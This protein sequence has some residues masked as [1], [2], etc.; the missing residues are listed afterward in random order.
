MVPLETMN[1]AP[2]SVRN[3]FP[4]LRNCSP[5]IQK[6]VLFFQLLFLTA[7]VLIASGLQ[8]WY[9]LNI[10]VP[11]L[12]ISRSKQ[13]FFYPIDFFCKQRFVFWQACRKFLAKNINR[14]NNIY[15]YNPSKNFP[16][17]VD[18]SFGHVNYSFVRCKKFF[19]KSSRSFGSKSE[20]FFGV[21][22]QKRVLL[23]ILLSLNGM[24][25]WK[26]LPKVI[27]RV[28]KTFG[29]ISQTH[30]E[31]KGSF[32]KRCFYSKN[33]WDVQC[34]FHKH[35]ENCLSK[36]R[37]VFAQS[38]KTVMKIVFILWKLSLSNGSLGNVKC[39]FDKHA[40]VFFVKYSTLSGPKS[41]NEVHFF[42]S[43]ETFHWMCSPDKWNAIL[44]TVPYV[45]STSPKNV[46][47]QKSEIYDERKYCFKK[48]CFNSKRLLRRKMQ[49][50]QTCRKVLYTT[51]VFQKS[52]FFI[53]LFS[54]HVQY[55]FD[56]PDEIY[57]TQNTEKSF[58]NILFS[59]NSFLSK[60]CVGQIGFIFDIRVEHYCQ[61]F[62]DFWIKIPKFL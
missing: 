27:P 2:S 49:F 52:L 17:H 12:Y 29:S 60:S 22:V 46:F 26:P 42:L 56:I 50:S 62:E 59:G 33:S 32:K 53:R 57:F 39:S 20:K 61:I 10:T 1:E 36:V 35:A 38:P 16:G 11:F 31:S 9:C 3:V 48:V 6:T 24:P 30:I 21:F 44:T 47:A 25:C 54:G 13:C 18:S 40:E 43:N 51:L 45:F 28:L 55:S 19:A 41:E 7:C 23:K 37:I 15:I 5:Q 8:L 14:N 58:E 4:K 34:N